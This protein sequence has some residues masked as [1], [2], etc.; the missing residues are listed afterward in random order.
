VKREWGEEAER[1][2]SPG[3]GGLNNPARE[4]LEL[5]LGRVKRTRDPAG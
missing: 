2:N 3:E 4:P 5:L 1:W